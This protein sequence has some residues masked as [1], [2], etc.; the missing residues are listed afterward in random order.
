MSICAIQ[1]NIV[2]M[3]TIPL[4]AIVIAQKNFLK[5][6]EKKNNNYIEINLTIKNTWF[7]SQFI[8]W[9][10]INNH[11]DPKVWPRVWVA[12]NTWY[13]VRIKFPIVDSPPF[14]QLLVPWAIGLIS[15]AYP[16]LRLCPRGLTNGSFYW[17]Y[18]AANGPVDN[19]N[20]WG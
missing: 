17:K 5:K 14:F 16:R 4:K 9:L 15:G 8:I 7:F 20:K 13:G 6:E 11:D 19:C 1:V 12:V 2:I 3:W 18:T 10:S